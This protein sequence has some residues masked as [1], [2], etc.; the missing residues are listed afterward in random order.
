MDKHY[1]GIRQSTV[2]SETLIIK[3]GIDWTCFSRR[4]CLDPTGLPNFP[5]YSTYIKTEKYKKRPQNILTGHN[6][7]QFTTK[8]TEWRW[9]IPHFASQIYQKRDFWSET[10]YLYH[11]ATLE[12]KLGSRTKCVCWKP[13][14]KK[15]PQ[16][17]LAINYEI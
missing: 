9:T 10:R 7:H 1:F 14:L 16:D 15:M 13:P 6:I 12:P 4:K 8:Y 5:W 11:L 3:L 17:I 2:Y